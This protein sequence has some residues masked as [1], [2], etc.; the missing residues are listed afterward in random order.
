MYLKIHL[1][2]KTK[3]YFKEK[4]S[5]QIKIYIYIDDMEDNILKE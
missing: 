1:R 4:I 5:L 3:N 2:K